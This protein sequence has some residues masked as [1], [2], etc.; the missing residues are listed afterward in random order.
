MRYPICI[1]F[2]KM[3]LSELVGLNQH[4]AIT[5]FDCRIVFTNLRISVII[6]LHYEK[7]AFILRASKIYKPQKCASYYWD[8]T[9]WKDHTYASGV[10]GSKRAKI[11]V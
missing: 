9:S 8:E 4:G 11:M 6:Y 2:Q 7:A 1:A 10:R 5:F 3:P